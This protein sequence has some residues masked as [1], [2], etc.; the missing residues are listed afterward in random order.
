MTIR[1][2]RLIERD[3]GAASRGLRW[4]ARRL[5]RNEANA[6]AALADL[7]KVPDLLSVDDTTLRREYLQGEPMYRARPTSRS[8]FVAALRLL[9]QLHRNGVA[10]NDLAKEPNWLVVEDGAPALLDYQL[11]WVSPRR[12]KLFRIL[13]YD[14]LRHLLKHKRTYCPQDL[15]ARQRR[16]LARRSWPAACWMRTVKPLY[17]FV[18][19]RL[20]GWADREGAADRGLRR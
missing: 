1:A 7:D 2:G 6:L 15:T 11:A 12:G 4:L 14:D 9:R 17:L 18:T 16:V 10:H 19:R 13:A 5:M 8:Y 20:I 3:V